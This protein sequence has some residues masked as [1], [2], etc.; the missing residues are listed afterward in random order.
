MLKFLHEFWAVF[1]P[2]NMLP[3]MSAQ[4]ER[5]LREL[6]EQVPTAFGL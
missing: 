1:K 3:Y 2:S 4:K 5:E 6:M